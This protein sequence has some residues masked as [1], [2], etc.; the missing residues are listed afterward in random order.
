M[1]PRVVLFDA[2]S[3]DG[4]IEGFS[5]DIGRFYDIARKVPEDVTLAGADTMLAGGE[6]IPLDDTSAPRP[7]S[8]SRSGPLIAIVDSRGRFRSWDWLREQP[9][10]RDAVALVSEATPPDYL[11]HLDARGVQWFRA[12]ADRVDLAAALEWLAEEHAATLVRVE[13]GGALNSALLSAG[14]A[15]ELWLLVHPVIAGAENRS[16]VRGDAVRGALLDL[17]ECESLEGGL[18]FMRYVVRKDA[19]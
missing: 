4:R 18:V 3:L 9:Y 17:A 6:A 19:M 2:V 14:L 12:G 11:E 13:S 16:F 8:P 7:P 5:A 10:W 1:L 15:D